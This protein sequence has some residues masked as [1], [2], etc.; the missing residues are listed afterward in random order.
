[1]ASSQTYSVAAILKQLL[2]E[3]SD[4][5]WDELRQA[6]LKSHTFE[7]LYLFS[8]LRRRA[9]AQGFTETAPDTVEI[10]VAIIG[11]YTFHP[12]NVLIEQTLYA[13]RYESQIWTGEY[14]NYVAEILD[15]ASALYSARPDLVILIPPAIRY[16]YSGNLSDPKELVE[17]EIQTN[18]NGLLDLCNKIH[19]VSSAEVVLFNFA[20]PCYFDPGPLRG[21]TLGSE[22]NSLKMLNLELGLNAPDYVHICDLE[23]LSA[24]VGGLNARDDRAWFESKQPFSSDFACL[25]AQEVG[26]VAS[27]LRTQSK[28]VLVMDLDETLWGGVITEDGLNGI[29]LGDTS[30]RGQCYKQFQKAILDLSRRGVLLAVCSK[31]DMDTAIEPFKD[32]PEM[33][34]RL[35]DIASF[36]A[37]WDDKPNNILKIAEE[38]N[39]GIDSFVFI[40]DNPAEIEIVRQFLPQ[41]NSIWLGSDPA[42]YL[43]TLLDCRFFENRAITEEDSKRVDLYRVERERQKLMTGTTDMD[44]YLESLEMVAEINWFKESDVPRVAQ[45]INKSNNFNLTAK[46]RSEAEVLKILNSDALHLS[47][48]LKDRFG[49]LGL[50]S[51]AIAIPQPDSTLLIDTW[52]MSCRVLRR[53]V[54]HVLMNR[55]LAEAKRRGYQRVTGLYIPTSKNLMVRDFYSSMGYRLVSTSDEKSEFECIAAD[56]KEV[57]TKISIAQPVGTAAALCAEH[58]A[59]GQLIARQLQCWPKHEKFLNK[60][61]NA[62]SGTLAA[63]TEQISSMI[64]ELIAPNPVEYFSNYKWLCDQINEETLHFLRTG[65]YRHSSFEEVNNS[66]YQNPTYMKSYLQG[67]LLSQV[68]WLNHAQVIDYYINHFLSSCAVDSALLEIGPGHGLLLTLAARSPNITSVEGWDISDSSLKMTGEHLCMLW[69]GDKVKLRKL[70]ITAFDEEL[71]FDAIVLSEVIE[72][73]EKPQIV[74]QSLARKMKPG[75]R[76]FI[77]VP[78]NSPAIDHI[79]LL[80]SP[81]EARKLVEDAGLAVIDFAV[82]PVTGYTEEQARARKITLSCVV[83]ASSK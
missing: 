19:L 59:T 5:F 66:V 31:N 45:L 33:V 52:V 2:S 41:L 24:R 65:R 44:T 1:M 79:F 56:Y 78:I 20:L 75:A 8:T 81:E 30:A 68:F 23:F 61:F 50:I 58:S 32:H 76:L 10:R 7:E 14:D 82:F 70:D 72:H 13:R 27:R 34:L 4:A 25:V 43:Q 35:D 3:K 57:P 62:R 63:T 73:L 38:L 48:R 53:H 64:Q 60:S 28:K 36:V 12:L 47:V 39:L 29:E 37:N 42:N 49:D 11:G 77:N 54:E 55:L 21:R 6:T 22:W 26:Q 51:V 40:D 46:R 16:R 67:I 80:E 17:R 83:V 69:K 9:L 74:L 15:D 71:H 18:L